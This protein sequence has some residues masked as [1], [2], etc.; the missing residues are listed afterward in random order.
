MD[1]DNFIDN[2]VT[3][4]A[5]KPMPSVL[6]QAALWLILSALW[7]AIMIAHAGL[8]PDLA[9]KLAQ[10]FYIPELIL[11]LV[12]AITAALTA[13][14]LSRPDGLQIKW[15]KFAPFGFLIAWAIA[16]FFDMA[17][18]GTPRLTEIMDPRQFDCVGCILTCCLPP[19]I[20]MFFIVR[21]GA[22][23]HSGQA[24]A[25]AAFSA[26]ALAYFCMRLIEANDHPLHLLIW[27]ALPVLIL[28]LVGL[29]AGKA[30]LRWK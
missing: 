7:L 18:M 25:I 15:I 6:K 28:S 2:L 11:L 9:D 20:A 19:A 12:V 29:L 24:G 23:T 17:P 16:A 5:H 13:L 8:R 21:M 10:P 1:T 22:P 14:C 4:G 26:T 27:H 30:F 3:Q